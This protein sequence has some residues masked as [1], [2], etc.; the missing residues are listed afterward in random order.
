MDEVWTAFHGLILFFGLITV[1]RLFYFLSISASDLVCQTKLAIWKFFDCTL[2]TCV[3]YRNMDVWQCRLSALMFGSIFLRFITT[4]YLQ[5]TTMRSEIN[6]SGC[7][8]NKPSR[9]CRCRYHSQLLLE[10]PCSFTSLSAIRR[11]VTR[12]YLQGEAKQVHV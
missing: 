7:F 12:L 10:Q 2:N 3:S 6:D 1:T 5:C 8:T 4:V 9:Y 11:P